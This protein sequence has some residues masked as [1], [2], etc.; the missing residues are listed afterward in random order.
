MDRTPPPRRRQS[1]TI[2]REDIKSSK[3]ILQQMGFSKSRA[4]KALA[5]TGDRDLQLA[6]DWLLSHVNDPELDVSAPRQYILYL[7]PVGPLQE[8]LM[9]FWE[10]SQKLCGWN[11]AHTYFPHITLCPF[12]TVEDSKCGMVKKALNMISEYLDECPGPLK[13]D[14]F[15]QN[16]F[17]GCFLKDNCYKYFTELVSKF[18]AECKKYGINVEPVKKQL[19]ITLAY[20][21]S[22]E[23]HEELMQQARGIDLNAACQWEVRLYSRD[24]RVGKSEVRRVKKTYHATLE[25]ELDLIIGDYVFMD[26]NEPT[27]STDQWYFGTSWLTGR[28]SMFPGPYTERTSETWT[29]ALHASELLVQKETPSPVCNGDSHAHMPLPK[30]PKASGETYEAVWKADPTYAKVNKEV[31]KSPVPRKEVRPQDLGIPRSLVVMRHG[32]RM[33]FLFG[34]SWVDLCFDD[35]GNYRP[36]DLNMPKS[37]PKRAGTHYEYAKDAPLTTLGSFQAHLTG[38]ALKSKGITFDHVYVSPSLRCVQT[39]TSVLKSMGQA[40]VP[41]H[42]EPG[43]FE[44]LGWYQLGLPKFFTPTELKSHGFNVDLS[45][46][47]FVPITKFDMEENI[48]GYYRR[49][50][51]T[52]RNIVIRHQQEG[53]NILILG[54]AGSLE[55]CTRQLLRKTPR[56][57]RD[58]RDL[59][60]KVPYC[61]LLS[62]TECLRTQKWSMGDAPILSLTHG[63]NKQMVMT[64]LFYPSEL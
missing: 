58:F 25:D 45:Y 30:P 47:P 9:T 6:S 27:R 23:Y 44:W 37:M 28:Q 4:E 17:I 3:D 41:L 39:A 49:S 10:R 2:R 21:Y 48:E 15:N 16:N 5:A 60:A 31:K 64:K 55:V 63:Q 53:G 35:D 52:S 43:I 32:E 34:R 57:D 62:I 13:L 8:Q 38:E 33:D 20:Q 22:S 50:G 29:W 26:P 42:V 54:H 19:H 7:C 12:F 1:S 11:G 40:T 61:G 18:G 56:P 46:K 14:F 36:S 51:E 59:C 24:P